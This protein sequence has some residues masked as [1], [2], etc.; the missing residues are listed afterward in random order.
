MSPVCT[1]FVSLPL[2]R[3][4]QSRDLELDRDTRLGEYAPQRHPSSGSTARK[5]GRLRQRRV[6]VDRSTAVTAIPLSA[7]LRRWRKAA[8]D[9]I[10]NRCTMLATNPPGDHMMMRPRLRGIHRDGAKEMQF[11]N[12]PQPDRSCSFGGG[13]VVSG[14]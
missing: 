10:S 3:P 7:S 1:A 13:A 14:S 2:G 12:V 8:S 9:G 6:L 4:Q 11:N 5:R